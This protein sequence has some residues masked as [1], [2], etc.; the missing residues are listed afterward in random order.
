MVSTR[1]RSLPSA[2]RERARKLRLKACNLLGNPPETD[3]PLRSRR[4]SARLR[5]PT[6]QSADRLRV[7]RRQEACRARRRQ[8]PR[9]PDRIRPGG[10]RSGTPSTRP[11]STS[12]TRRGVSAYDGRFERASI[13]SGESK[14]SIQFGKARESQAAPSR[15][16]MA[17]SRISSPPGSRRCSADRAR[18]DTRTGQD[19]S[20]PRRARRH[21]HHRRLRRSARRA[22][23]R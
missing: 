19:G 18:H 8:H 3:G 23:C 20:S 1:S 6:G 7:P 15:R 11:A 22:H 10:R 5:C 17:P 13:G 16:R 21:P 2:P 4:C 9:I 14:S 12:P